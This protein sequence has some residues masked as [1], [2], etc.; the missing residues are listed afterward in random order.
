MPKDHPLFGWLKTIAW[1]R[2]VKLRGLSKV[3]WLV[4]LAWP[5]NLRRLTTLMAAP[6]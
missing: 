4:C 1:L 3:P 5:F 2:K 6:A